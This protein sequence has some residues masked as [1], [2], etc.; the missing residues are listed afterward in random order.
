MT[1]HFNPL[2][3]TIQKGILVKVHEFQPEA[4]EETGIFIPTL[5]VGTTDAGNL[6]TELDEFRAKWSNV[7]EVIQ[8]HSSA[9]DMMDN[10]KNDTKIGDYIQ[11]N[12]AALSSHNYYFTE[13]TPNRYFTGY[14]ILTPN[15]IISKF[16]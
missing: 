1:K 14:L 8:I 2:T 13:V 9:Q 7:A 11:F 4:Q 5:Q 16:N 3:A 10:L 12:E 6:S 15:N